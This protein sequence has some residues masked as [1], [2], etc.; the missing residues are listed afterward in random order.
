MAV[1]AKA[2]SVPDRT[3][4]LTAGTFNPNAGGSRRRGTST[5][6]RHADDLRPS[7]EQAKGQQQ[8]CYRR[9][10][11]GVSPFGCDV[12]LGYPAGDSAP[13]RR[14]SSRAKGWHGAWPGGRERGR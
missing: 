8:G 13:A 4:E 9:L 6:A 3:V 2:I 1:P 7:D 11:T 5:S 14:S 12:E 10:F